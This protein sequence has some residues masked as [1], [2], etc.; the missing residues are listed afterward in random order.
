[1]PL[2]R[3]AMPPKGD[4]IVSHEPIL[5]LALDLPVSNESIAKIQAGIE[6]AGDGV[7]DPPT[8]FRLLLAVEEMVTNVVKYGNAASQCLSVA[9][10]RRSED[11]T[12]ELGYGGAAFDPFSDV[13]PP[14]LDT[15]VDSRPLGGL[16]IHLVREMIDKC[17]YRRQCDRNI[18]S[19]VMLR[20][21]TAG[22]AR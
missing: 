17:Y 21:G 11:V 12:I 20:S 9:I 6:K 4:Q 8:I 16:G 13:P 14:A 5:D 1:M 7:L 19:L 2:T 3:Q 15:P 18:L 10:Y 22:S